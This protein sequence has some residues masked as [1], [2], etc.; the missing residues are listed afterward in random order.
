MG[1][2]ISLSFN[3][4][5]IGTFI[6]C[7]VEM[8]EMVIIVF[9]VGA[10]R[11]WRSTSIG[12]V[13]GLVILVGIIVGLG[14]AIQFI[15]IDIARVVIG[16]LLLTFGLQWYRQGVIGV[17]A[18]GFTGGGGEEV[19][20]SGGSTGGV[21]DWTSFTLAFKGVLLEGLEV[22]FIVIAF[23]T[24]GM[25]NNGSSGAVGNGFASAYTG[26]LASFLLIW[27][28]GFVAKS[29]LEQVP[30]RVLKFGVGGLL[31]TFGTF[32][33]LEGLGVHWPGEDLSLVWLY[34]LYLGSTVLLMLAVRRGVM[35]PR[36]SS[37]RPAPGAIGP[38]GVAPASAASIAEFQGEHGLTEDGV[39][40]ARTRAA[41]RA[42]R[43]EHNGAEADA[44]ALGLDPADPGSVLAFQ[45]RFGLAET[46]D[47]D[48]A[49]RGALRVAQ[50]PAIVDFQDPDT[51]RDFQRRH[52]LEPD[53]VA[54]ERT[55][56][57]A[58]AVA[59]EPVPGG[60]GSS[61][62]STSEN[63]PVQAFG[64]M[65]ALDEGA[66]CR[67]Q[68]SLGLL[69]DGVI[70]P[71]TRGAFAAMR[72]AVGD[73][74]LSI[75]SDGT[76]LPDPSDEAAVREFQNRHGLTA[77]GLIGSRTRQAL[78]WEL[79]HHAGMDVIDPGSVRQFQREHGLSADGVVGEQ[80][81]AALRA[82]RHDLE[83]EDEQAREQRYGGDPEQRV[84]DRLLDP[85]EPE[86]IR[87]FQQRHRLADDGVLGPRTR[88]ALQAVRAHRGSSGQDR[89][90]DTRRE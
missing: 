40:G 47:V 77:D 44:L 73:G 37:A 38:G 1:S 42:V 79:E 7:S 12:A 51:V 87:R 50:H 88:S 2:F 21:L 76:T 55:R 70:G 43:S 69:G 6:A 27:T 36:P 86:E 82:L 29:K 60:D 4:V 11:G 67:F 72:V 41:M 26:A 23:G 46:A 75:G 49:T 74:Q 5:L 64:S 24:G 52:G 30:G 31:S 25:G 58:R 71:E 8:I 16:A 48:A 84:D 9:G 81:S 39:I 80:T 59:A 89:L 63:D 90:Q 13:S 20:A 56:V 61:P 66:V 54:G 78:R 33:M 85:G 19:D 45:R 28:L 17:A 35:G 18:E 34:A 15:P 57:A 53:G 62:A 14:R 10:I 68:T 83:P 65:D 32:W 3:T 22:A